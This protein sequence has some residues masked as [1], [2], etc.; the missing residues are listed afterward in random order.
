MEP[1][2]AAGIATTAFSTLFVLL[3]IFTKIRVAQER[4]GPAD[5]TF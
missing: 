3:R 1:H 2:E 5:C 4:L